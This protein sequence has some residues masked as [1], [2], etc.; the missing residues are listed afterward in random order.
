MIMKSVAWHADE[1]DDNFTL[2]EFNVVKM[3]VLSAILPP[4]Y[5]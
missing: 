5:H 3:A 2:S 4:F 1:F